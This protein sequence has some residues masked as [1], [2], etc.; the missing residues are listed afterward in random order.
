MSK[1]KA[2]VP[3]IVL[4]GSRHPRH[5]ISR[6]PPGWYLNLSWHCHRPHLSN[7]NQVDEHVDLSL[8]TYKVHPTPGNSWASGLTALRPFLVISPC[9]FSPSQRSLTLLRHPF[10]TL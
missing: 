6:F 7:I 4:R 9:L 1:V 2:R 5:H 10:L 8:S 3:H